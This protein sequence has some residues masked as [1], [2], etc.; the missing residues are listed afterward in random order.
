MLALQELK[1]LGDQM[2]SISC[3]DPYHRTPASGL[4]GLENI[5]LSFKSF[6]CDLTT[7]VLRIGAGEKLISVAYAALETDYSQRKITWSENDAPRHLEGSI[8]Q[9]QELG[10][11]GFAHV[12]HMKRL[13]DR[14]KLT[15]HEAQLLVHTRHGFLTEVRE[16]LYKYS[17]QEPVPASL[18]NTQIFIPSRFLKHLTIME[19]V[20]GLG[21]PDCL[22]RSVSHILSDAGRDVDW[23]TNDV[24]H[25]DALGRSGLY[26]SCQNGDEIR[27]KEFIAKGANV[28]Q[29]AMNGLTPMHIAACMGHTTIFTI[30][31][32]TRNG[33][34]ETLRSCGD[35]RDRSGRH[36][37]L[38]AAL[39]GRHETVVRFFEL[40]FKLDLNPT[41]DMDDFGCTAVT[42]AACGGHD[43]LVQFL[44]NNYFPADVQDS[45]GRTAFWYAAQGGH[46]ATMKFL[47]EHATVDHRDKYGQTPLAEAARQGQTNALNYLLSLN[48]YTKLFGVPILV[49]V[50]PDS[51]DNAG[52]SALVHAAEN[53]HSRCVR[54]LLD[55][56]HDTFYPGA[57]QS[58]I[59]DMLI[60]SRIARERQDWSTLR[61]LSRGTGKY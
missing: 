12:L 41:L 6:A 37:L 35:L 60:V 27:V 24:H 13:L 23:S 42:L 48:Q 56:A 20:Q 1:T 4:P 17:I 46:E 30:L 29:P 61:A 59:Q 18:Y 8:A 5:F 44:V 52:K 54:S 45:N 55:Q 25:V 16:T 57:S 11:H 21:I 19:N 2:W 22:G 10:H 38:W 9:F 49:R 58:R 28:Y 50:D 53:G 14:P 33:R 51:R 40:C 47:S 15:D 39:W 36:P 34:E 3:N 31:W 7:R 26:I 32:N 43:K